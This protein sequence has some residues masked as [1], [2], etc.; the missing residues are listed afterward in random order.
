MTQDGGLRNGS[1]VCQK[2]EEESAKIGENTGFPLIDF[3]SKI[4]SRQQCKQPWK[5]GK[6]RKEEGLSLVP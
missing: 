4:G 1:I 3:S 6:E 2:R 5:D